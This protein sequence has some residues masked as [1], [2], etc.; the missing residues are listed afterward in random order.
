MDVSGTDDQRFTTE[1]VGRGGKVL[2]TVHG[3]EASYKIR[4]GEGYVR[5]RVV[6][7]NGRRAWTQA[8]FV[9]KR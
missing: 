3:Q 5:A 2:A 6:D 1:F 4:G 7:S 8:V 9:G